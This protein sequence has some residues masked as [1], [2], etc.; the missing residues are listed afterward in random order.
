MLPQ[1]RQTGLKTRATVSKS[2]Q[3]ITFARTNNISK[4]NRRV[5]LMNLKKLCIEGNYRQMNREFII[6]ILTSLFITFSH[7]C[8]FI[9]IIL[10]F[11]IFHFDPF[12][13]SLCC[14]W[15]CVA[16]FFSYPY[17]FLLFVFIPGFFFNTLIFTCLFQT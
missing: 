14:N 11:I 12:I 9:I 1:K 10:M 17:E 13:Y 2:V 5:K 4:V 15:F 3:S 16:L 7:V 8:H 6:I